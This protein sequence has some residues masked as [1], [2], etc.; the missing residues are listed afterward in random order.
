MSDI[1]R[2]RMIPL[3]IAD[4]A[5]AACDAEIAKLREEVQRLEAVIESH[6]DAGLRI[7][8]MLDEERRLTKHLKA[9]VERLTKQNALATPRHLIASQDITSLREQVERLKAELSN[10]TG[11]GRGLESDLSW[12]RAELMLAKAEVERLTKQ[13]DYERM[14]RETIELLKK[15]NL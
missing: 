1:D 2:T 10:I 14:Y 3:H 4:Q 9:E 7:L 11:W 5:V 8:A 13:T 15:N 12:A 6:K